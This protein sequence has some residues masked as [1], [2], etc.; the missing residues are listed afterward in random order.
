MKLSILLI[1]ILLQ[2]SYNAILLILCLFL[3]S[4][5]TGFFYLL[6]VIAFNFFP[7]PSFPNEVS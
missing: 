4:S 7:S 1:Y 3:D 5:D 6:L 2:I